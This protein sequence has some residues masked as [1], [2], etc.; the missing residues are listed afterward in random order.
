[1]VSAIRLPRSRVLVFWIFSW[2]PTIV[3]A[4]EDNKVPSSANV[5]LPPA[6]TVGPV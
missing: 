5:M 1:M 3:I 6:L 4:D 2:L